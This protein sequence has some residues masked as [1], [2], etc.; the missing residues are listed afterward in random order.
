MHTNK[1]P[2]FLTFFIF[3]IFFHFFIPFLYAYK[4]APYIYIYIERERESRIER[5]HIHYLLYNDKRKHDLCL[6]FLR[7]T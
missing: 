2:S 4:Q 5:L 1:L 6:H 3:L 7:L